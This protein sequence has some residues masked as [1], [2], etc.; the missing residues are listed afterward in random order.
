[1]WAQLRASLIIP[2]SR[3]PVLA[4]LVVVLGVAGYGVYYFDIFNSSPTNGITPGPTPAPVASAERKEAVETSQSSLKGSEE[5][6]Q[7]VEAPKKPAAIQAPIAAKHQPPPPP[8]PPPPQIKEKKQPLALAKVP[9][10]EAP[11]EPAEEITGKDGAPMVR[12]PAGEFLY[13]DNN[14]RI[15]LPVFYMDKFEVTTARYARFMAETRREKPIYWEDAVPVSFGDRPVV[16]VT[17]HDAD[18]Y[19]RYYGKRLPT[20]QEWEKAARG[21][22][23][24]KYPWG[25]ELPT[26]RHANFEKSKW[27]G[28]T[29][30]ATVESYE[31]GKSPYGIYHMAGNVWEWTSSDYDNNNKV[32]RG[33]SWVSFAFSL[34][35]T[36]RTWWAPSLRNYYRGFRCLQDSPQ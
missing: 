20:E 21:T 18:A 9:T 33:G 22:D 5:Q 34:E 24:R 3:L 15:T 8:P 16:G 30:L 10:Y 6:K 29:T 35:S 1:M 14:Q 27:E 23:G 4:S 17:W 26:S 31:A 11:R 2:L 13:G 19:C 36:F 28:Y 32:D 12:V 25:K 7:P